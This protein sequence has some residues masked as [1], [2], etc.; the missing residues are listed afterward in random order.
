[1]TVASSHRYGPE[2][3]LQH[4]RPIALTQGDPSGIGPEITLRAWLQRRTGDTPF[5]VLAD[6]DHLRRSAKALKLDVPIESCHP[7]DAPAVFA[8]ALPVAAIGGAIRGEPGAPDPADASLTIA[9]IDMAVRDVH[10]GLACAVA[11]NPI[12][13]AS[14]YKAGFKHPGHTEFLGELARKYF[15][16][17]A[18]PVM[19]LWSPELAVVP[20]TIHVPLAQVLRMIDED[21]IISTGK[22]V[23]KAMRE[24][25]GIANPR[26]AFSGLNPHA[27]EQGALGS[28]ENE[29]I[30]P[31]L[32]KLRTQGINALGPFPGDTMFHAQARKGYDAAL[33]MYHDQALIPIK[34]IS[35]DT[36]VN[37]T[38]GLPFVRTSPDH[39][40]AYDIAGKGIA[41][42][43]SLI[44]A[45]ALAAKLGAQDM[46]H[47]V[48]RA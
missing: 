11:T 16:V 38:L 46:A 45:L 39:G 24:Q 48:Q 34:T 41:R 17:D 7:E 26:L 25:F 13:K 42:P 3:Q 30:G 12:T 14:L 9:S 28:E 35:F 29:I 1:M 19:M 15:D 21:L 20:I 37:V 31:A 6:S 32:A 27:G 4:D 43:D 22:I 36:A 8:R 18:T 2:E 40:T 47:R 10:A 5:Y 44:A 23:A 33:C